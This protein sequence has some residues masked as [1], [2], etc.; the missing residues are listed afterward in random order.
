MISDLAV[1]RT[2]GRLHAIV[3]PEIMLFQMVLILR[4][5]LPEIKTIDF[6]NII[7]GADGNEVIINI[8]DEKYASDLLMKLWIE[9]GRENINQIERKKI[10]VNIQS[11]SQKDILDEVK[12]Q[13]FFLTHSSQE[14]VFT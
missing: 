12:N 14:R 7:E 11:Q 13:K 10:I 2:I 5:R 1:A 9:Y 4:E 6:S 8:S 3:K